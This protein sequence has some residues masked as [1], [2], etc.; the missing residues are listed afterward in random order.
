LERV[1]RTYPREHAKVFTTR[2]GTLGRIGP[3]NAKAD[4]MFFFARFRK[5]ETC[6]NIRCLSSEDKFLTP[7]LS[8]EGVIA[9]EI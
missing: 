3:E 8:K 5:T 9:E 7:L 2:R 1:C 6:P 4:P